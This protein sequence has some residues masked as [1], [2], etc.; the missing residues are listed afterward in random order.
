MPW[1]LPDAGNK[2]EDNM[3]QNPEKLAIHGGKPIRTKPLDMGKKHT[4]AEWRALKPMFERGSIPMTRGPEV[5]KLREVF[6][7]RFGMKYAVT[8]SS[9]T[10]AIHTALAAAGV[11]RGDEVITSPFTDMGSLVGILQLNAVPVFADVDPAMMM[12]TPQT[13]AARLGPRTGAVEVVHVAGLAA[14]TLGIVRLCRPRKITVIED[15]AQS[16]LCTCNGRIAGTIGDMG[17]WSF[18]E[19]KHIGAGD[20]GMLLTNKAALAHRSDL[21]ADKCYDRE[22]GHHDPFFAPVTYR[23]N[24]LAAAVL[25]EQ[26]KHLDAL[27]AKRNRLGSWLDAQLAKIPGISTRPVRKGDFATYWYYLFRIDPQMFGVSNVEFAKALN[28]EGVYANAPHTMSVLGWRLFAKD[29]DD[30]HACSFHCPLYKGRRPNYD[31]E[32]FPGLRQVCRQAV[33]MLISPNFTMADMADKAA[34]VAKVARFYSNR[35]GSRS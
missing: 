20:G 22:G 5:M 6:R 21:F 19:S 28:A 26:F 17:C 12:M 1:Q 31:P 33:E 4:L 35:K 30:R 32:D 25:L 18:N 8:A 14:D 9:G 24:A 23:L 15:C 34:A 3:T 13:V 2:I 10:A 16:Y 11:G 7:K 29:T 27:A